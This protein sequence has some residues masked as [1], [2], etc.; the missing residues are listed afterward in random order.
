MRLRSAISRSGQ[1]G[2][3]S[4]WKYHGD[5]LSASTS[6]Y[7]FMAAMT[8]RARGPKPAGENDRFI[9]KRAPI[10]GN[11]RLSREPASCLAGQT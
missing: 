1:C 8:T 10:G 4:P 5:P 7:F 3:R 2:W 11:R 6:P 9:R